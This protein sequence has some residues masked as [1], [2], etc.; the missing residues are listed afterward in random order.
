MIN[1]IINIIITICKY[2]INKQTKKQEKNPLFHNT[3]Q[4]KKQTQLI[5]RVFFSRKNKKR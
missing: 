4:P 1:I 3:K 2:N 5:M